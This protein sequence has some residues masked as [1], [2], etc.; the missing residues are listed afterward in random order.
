MF[1]IMGITNG[2][3]DFDFHQT[4]ICNLCGKY[5]NYTVFMTY[6]VLSLFFIPCIKWGKRYYVQTGCCQAIYEL[7]PEVGRAIA[8]GEDVEIRPEHLSL[9]SNS[10]YGSAHK[11]C[12]YCGYETEEDFEFCPKC[13]NRF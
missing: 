13:G 6:T 5:G 9:V 3:K 7:N 12:N 11:H 2:R 1:F 4:M 8:K 10:R